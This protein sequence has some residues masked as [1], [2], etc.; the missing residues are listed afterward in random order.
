MGQLPLKGFW[1]LRQPHGKL[2][3]NDSLLFFFSVS[4]ICFS[5]IFLYVFL[6]FFLSLLIIE[7]VLF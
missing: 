4:N 1:F 7:F 2:C 6:S 5:S 3:D